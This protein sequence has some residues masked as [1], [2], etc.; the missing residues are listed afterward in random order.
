MTMTTMKTTTRRISLR[1]LFCIVIFCAAGVLAKARDATEKDTTEAAKM[2][3]EASYKDQFL[4]E[5]QDGVL[6][7]QEDMKGWINYFN[8]NVNDE[9]RRMQKTIR[10]TQGIYK[11][12]LMKDVFRQRA[13]L[14]RLRH[15]VRDHLG[16]VLGCV[17]AFRG[18]TNPR[19]Y[20]GG[21]L[22]LQTSQLGW[23]MIDAHHA[24]PHGPWLNDATA[25]AIGIAT[26]KYLPATIV[27]KLMPPFFLLS[28]LFQ[29]WSLVIDEWNRQG[30]DKIEAPIPYTVLATGLAWA[31]L[32]TAKIPIS[33]AAASVSGAI[34]A[35]ES[36]MAEIAGN[37][38]YMLEAVSNTVFRVLSVLRK[39]L[40]PVTRGLLW[41]LRPITRGLLWL[42]RLRKDLAREIATRVAEPYQKAF[43]QGKSQVQ[44]FI[45]ENISQPLKEQK[46]Y[47]QELP[48]TLSLQAFVKRFR[49]AVKPIAWPCAIAVCG[50]AFQMNYV[51]G[52]G[53]IWRVFKIAMD[54][55]SFVIKRLKGNLDL[56][57][58]LKK[59]LKSGILGRVV[60][61]LKNKTQQ[62]EETTSITPR[63]RPTFPLQRSGSAK[64]K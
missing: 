3:P 33:L 1:H 28:A 25:V 37:W 6:Q 42:W 24:L 64:G 36:A 61:A 9:K 26:W 2:N 54:P 62:K 38:L 52:V 57:K 20:N 55:I 32:A 34:L 7:A 29:A 39:V 59:T 27:G 40:R 10:K 44:S 43:H 13:G 5:A 56:K 23:D 22:A 63:G 14:H 30:S 51:Q 12:R 48:V 15:S 11:E 4:L 47:I 60:A 17:V 49:K 16:L 18:Y 35:Y 31:A 50:V 45:S 41:L 46:S 53:G 58:T 21:A 8:S 19:L